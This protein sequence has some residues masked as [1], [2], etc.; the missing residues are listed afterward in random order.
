MNWAGAEDAVFYLRFW[1][2]QSTI[3]IRLDSPHSEH[4]CDNDEHVVATPAGKAGRRQKK[5]HFPQPNTVQW[6]EQK[7]LCNLTRMLPSYRARA[8]WTLD[9]ATPY[10]DQ[11]LYHLS[12]YIYIYC[13]PKNEQVKA[14]G[15]QDKDN[16]PKLNEQTT[17]GGRR[18]MQACSR[19]GGGVGGERGAERGEGEKA[20]RVVESI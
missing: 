10:Y 6:L 2:V 16:F 3:T 19:N 15:F 17:D 20:G 12:I 14:A 9:L 4:A 8:H 13:Y 1:C 5:Q 7:R 11:E 18:S